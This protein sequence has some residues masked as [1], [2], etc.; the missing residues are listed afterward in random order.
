M[1]LEMAALPEA[2]WANFTLERS[3]RL[4]E[5]EDVSGVWKKC[6]SSLNKFRSRNV[7]PLC[8]LEDAS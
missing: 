1:R 3:F 8:E 5:L 4:R 6:G 7:G 2:I